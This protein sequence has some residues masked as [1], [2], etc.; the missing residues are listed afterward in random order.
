MPVVKA[1]LVTIIAESGLVPELKD[2]VQQAGAT[3][4]TIE[5]VA[6][7]F[8]THGARDGNFEGDQ[9]VKML[10]IVS[11]PIAHKIFEEI[12]KALKPHTALMV[13][14]HEVEARMP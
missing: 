5:P 2:L 6:S 1:T 3:G 11:Q 8:G 14:R 7:G 10:L 9:T 13:F 4:Y 12:E